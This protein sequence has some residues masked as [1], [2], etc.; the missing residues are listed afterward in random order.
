VLFPDVG[1]STLVFSF[2]HAVFDYLSGYSFL[3]LLL[4]EAATAANQMSLRQNPAVGAA[5]KSNHPASIAECMPAEV[6]RFGAARSITHSRDAV[7][8]AV[9]LGGVDSRSSEDSEDAA[10]I[11]NPA[12]PL[13]KVTASV[14]IAYPKTATNKKQQQ[15]STST[16]T[17]TT[18]SSSYAK[19]YLNLGSAKPL[20]HQQQ[21]ELCFDR[22]PY[23]LVDCSAW[24][25]VCGGTVDAE[26]GGLRVEPEAKAEAPP[27]LGSPSSAAAASAAA[28]S[29]QSLVKRLRESC[30]FTVSTD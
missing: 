26:F 30:P 28:S 19:P 25:G 12:D 5:T 9:L 10:V 3:H 8:S 15:S 29:Q 4:Q 6:L 16:T 2:D 11:I 27:L 21:Q 1:K 24:E 17:T 20:L 18:N 13:S 22:R 7:A 23:Q 14:S